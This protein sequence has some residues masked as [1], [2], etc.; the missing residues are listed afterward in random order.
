MGVP[1]FFR[2]I[3]ERYPCLSEFVR[4]YQIPVFDNLYLDMNGIIHMCSHPDDNN[5]HFRITEEKIF[6]DIF[7]YIEVLFR[8]IKP[9]KIFFMAVDG[10]AP[11]AKMNQQRGRR[12]RSA[13]D[14]EKLE[15]EALKKGEKL[16]DVER[17]DSNCITP[18]TAF[19]A[20]LHE[21][22]KYFVVEKISTDKMWKKCKVI[23]SGHETPGEGEHK[24]MDYIRYLRAQ[25]GYDPNTRHCLY[26]LDADLIMLGLCTHDPHFS[27]LR[28]EVKFA[29]KAKRSNVPE[30]IRFYL[31][32]LSLMREYLE[33][34]FAPLKEKLKNVPTMEFDIE[35]I[36]D[37][38]ILMGF[39]VGNDFIPN[40]PNL[41]I[42][43]GALPV[44]YEAYIDVLPTLNGYINE[45]GTLNLERF[46]KFM[47]KLANIDQKNFEETQDDLLYMER[48][49]GRKQTFHTPVQSKPI[50]SDSPENNCP[51]ETNKDPKLA[52]LIAETDEWDCTSED[53][54]DKL[55]S[56]NE[57]EA[58]KSFKDEYYRNKLEFQKVTPEVMRE[59]AEGYVRA[60]QWNLNYY[61]N[62]VCSWSWFYPHHYS[63]YISDV[64]GFANL[65][66]DFE[67]GKPFKPY[68]Q[69]LAVLPTAS[70]NLLPKCYHHLMTEENSIIKGYYPEEFQTD[71]NG[72][73][74][75]WEAVVL[76]P[77]IDEE[78][79]L[80][81]MKPCNKLLSIEEVK[82][83]QHGP[84]LVY[85]YTDDDL[86]VYE[87]PSYFPS[88]QNQA[89][90][91]PVDMEE[92]RVPKEKLIKGAYPG[93]C[94]DV[95]YP[96][97]PT[98]KHLR[99]TAEFKKAK[100][101][102]FEM[103]SRNDNMILKIMPNEQYFVDES[104]PIDLLGNTVW[105]GWPHLVEAK[106][107]AV[108][109]K[110]QKYIFCKNESRGYKIENQVLFDSE[111][112][113][114]SHY[115]RDRMGIE[116]GKTNILVH[117]QL[118]TG[119][120]YVFTSGRRVTLEK[121][122]SKI[123]SAYPLQSTVVDI[124]VHDEYQ[125]AYTDIADV[126]PNGSFCFSLTCPH[127][128]SQGIV[129]ET[130]SNQV[131]VSLS[132]V[133][134]PNFLTAQEID[135]KLKNSYL[136]LTS[137]A[138]QLSISN[139]V[140]S[141]ITGS[142]FVS[143]RT[144]DGSLKSVNVG[145]DLKFNKKN[146][147]TPGYTRKLENTWY[148]TE[149]AVDL[150]RR[151]YDKFPEIIDFLY[152]R[153][154]ED[155]ASD[156]IFEDGGDEKVR[157]IQVWLKTL[158]TYNIERRVCGTV[159]LE[160]EVVA[161]IENIV[162]QFE[163]T[164]KD[165]VMQVKPQ[166]LYKPEIQMG[167][168][169]PDPLSTT[170]LFDR[171]VNVRE[172][173][174]VPLGLKGTVIGVHKSAS[175]LKT[176][177]EMYD[178]VFDK[179]FA[180]GLALNCSEYKGYRLPKSSFINLTHGKRQ[181]EQKMGIPGTLRALAKE[182]HSVSSFNGGTSNSES[183]SPRKQNSAFA[184]FNKTPL[185]LPAPSQNKS[186]CGSAQI[187]SKQYQ[188]L[189]PSH[190]QQKSKNTFYY[191][192]DFTQ[193]V[194]DSKVNKENSML[195]ND[196]SVNVQSKQQIS[197]GPQSLSQ[198]PINSRPKSEVNTDFLKRILNIQSNSNTNKPHV[199]N[200]T[201]QS[202]SYVAP[203]TDTARSYSRNSS[204]REHGT[205]S[206][207]ATASLLSYYQ[208]NLLGCPRYTYLED[209]DGF[210]AQ[211][212]LPNGKVISGKPA[213]TREEASENVAMDT[214][215]ILQ[216]SRSSK[217]GLPSKFPVPPTKWVQ[218]KQSQNKLPS[219]IFINKSHQ[220][221]M[222]Q[223]QRG[224]QN[225]TDYDRKEIE[226]KSY[227]YAQHSSRLSTNTNNTPNFVPLQALKKKQVNR[228]ATNPNK[229]HSTNSHYVKDDQ[230]GMLNS[231]V[232]AMDFSKGPGAENRQ[233]Y[234]K[235]RRYR[236]TR[237]AANFNK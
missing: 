156:M 93:A 95:F 19:M 61:Y 22:L 115:Y 142:L 77:F 111:L 169:A 234:E 31:L 160:P 32:H 184:S 192:A 54:S 127:Y 20:R 58:F 13:K 137:A 96:G 15:K 46:E 124:K 97:F 70:K 212:A 197:K 236:K 72:K 45:A 121:Q 134:E 167:T 189:N 177:D 5:P 3:S 159:I 82:R 40:L 29:K 59:Q 94:F 182:H 109:N 150:V 89:R 129:I 85:E 36:I 175:S 147:E 126:F 187:H 173:F 209:E 116:L 193:T 17:F 154:N 210:I 157:S 203:R 153:G 4:D 2:Y 181:M 18:G 56:S 105:V 33:L 220:V 235:P 122:F 68:E 140:F 214:L 163:E 23:L 104:V 7:H 64:K 145:L 176:E 135:E 155:L 30:E 158:P 103:P 170:K 86:G 130:G 44:L 139:Y 232:Q 131:K 123:T 16:P 90:C 87:A 43:N 35:K 149:K 100:I 25:P 172:G 185:L 138:S 76:V 62:G 69:L 178:V 201:N 162:D 98:L 118:M 106:V 217:D 186:Q 48:K 10:V 215:A 148:Y 79:L 102:V 224:P 51:K 9:Q 171:I 179:V 174:T 208:S 81:A 84:M 34:E 114:I 75:E 133:G 53:E 165:F 211:V 8:M 125:S 152:D 26:G 42:A 27:L 200:S 190:G 101:K 164:P 73:R 202:K 1:K 88:V 6:A 65:K 112:E 222:K 37:D 50:I 195:Q 74:Q 216:T 221:Q 205:N 194:V 143:T 119:R 12:F 21:Q 146:Q 41:H 99:Y 141:R 107:V 188:Q 229:I 38:W 161:E 168:L 196:D 71:L 117:V 83:N 223:H 230:S 132:L 207:S 237:I 39:L 183:I 47:K 24:I 231:T 67:L 227:G 113:G 226:P 166:L 136:S 206:T 28:E 57:D 233:R 55:S 52:A 204:K 199:Q 80:E 225:W 120:K 213:R 66:I 11:R 60:I 151:Y 110:K 92:I 14:A 219:Q 78:V 128:G 228:T 198:K 180:G 218:D 91:I 144:L 108:S 49:T 63:P 191:M